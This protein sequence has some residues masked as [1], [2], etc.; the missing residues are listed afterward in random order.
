MESKE[1]APPNPASVEAA[2]KK[3]CIALKKRLNEI[4][5]ENDAMRTRNERG[6]RYIQKMRLESAMLLQQLS[7][8]TRMAEEPGSSGNG[9]QPGERPPPNE[10]GALSEAGGNGVSGGGGNQENNA[11]AYMDD[12]TEGSSDDHPPTPQER[13]LRAKR[14]RRPDVIGGDDSQVV[15]N[16][17]NHGP[18]SSNAHVIRPSPLS[19]PLPVDGAQDASPAPSGNHASFRVT[20]ASGQSTPVPTSPHDPPLSNHNQ[21]HLSTS[22]NYAMSPAPPNAAHSDTTP[23][24]T[25][26]NHL[27]PVAIKRE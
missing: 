24:D 2:Y 26:D 11:D 7:V 25:D 20:N 8:I 23:M 22:T 21:S 3:K 12:D 1:P 16:E 5:T 4:E 15:I 10:P 9:A 18:S 6:Q 19:R 17:Q 27:D 14:S 13:P